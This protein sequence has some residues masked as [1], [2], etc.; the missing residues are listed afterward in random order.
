[1]ESSKNELLNIWKPIKNKLSKRLEDF[2]EVWKTYPEEELFGEL[3]FCI[4]TPQSSAKM[5]WRAIENLKNKNLLLKGKKEQIEK[6]LFG[7]RFKYTKAQR[8]VEAREK[9][10]IKSASHLCAGETSPEGRGKISLRKIL[11]EHTNCQ[12]KREWLVQN[13][14]GIGYK[15]A[16]HFLRNIGFAQELAI[17]DRHILKNLKYFGVISEIP[18][19][20]TKSKYFEIENLMKK[21]AKKTGIPLDHMDLLF[22]QK[23]TGEVFK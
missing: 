1:M 14:K 8:I 6:E 23:E 10:T 20:L 9:V 18:K 11:N 12:L 13:I 4:L 22:W 21:F 7:V 16:G 15:E 3:A 17:L 19:T 5:C 2:H